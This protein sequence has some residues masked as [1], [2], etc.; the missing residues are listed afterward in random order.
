MQKRVEEIGKHMQR[1]DGRTLC[2][3]FQSR[4]GSAPTFVKAWWNL[5]ETLVEPWKNL[6]QNLLVAQINPLGSPRRIRPN[7][8][9]TLRN[10]EN[11]GGTFRVLQ[12]D[13]HFSLIKQK[14]YIYIY[15]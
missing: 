2:T 6:P 9:E 5:S 12:E 1:S 7:E 14:Q 3:T 15:I 13:I 4:K 8:P 11:L 10:L